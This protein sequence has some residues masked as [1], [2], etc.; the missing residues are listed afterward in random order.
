M[1]K[2]ALHVDDLRVDSFPVAA[3]AAGKGTVAAHEFTVGLN[4]PETN[5]R[6]CPHT[7]AAGC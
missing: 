7:C 3:G 1:K 4:C 2:I 6:T 5:Y